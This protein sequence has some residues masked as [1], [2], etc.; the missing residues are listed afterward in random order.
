MT[1]VSAASGSRARSWLALRSAETVEQTSRARSIDATRAWSSGRSSYDGQSVRC[2]DRPPVR[3]R[4]ISSVVSGS[5]GATT[6]HTVSS[7]VY[8]VSNAAVA[9]SS[10][11]PQNR[12]RERRM[13][14]LVSTSRNER[15]VSQA[16]AISYASIWVCIVATNSRSLASR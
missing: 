3:P 12:S 10:S 14:Q 5:S 16:L 7:V 9:D 8:S 1:T 15:I 6:R 13:Y 4:Q 2:T 11:P